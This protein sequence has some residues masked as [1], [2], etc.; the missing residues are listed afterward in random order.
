MEYYGPDETLR[1]YRPKQRRGR[2]EDRE[3]E[4]EP[5]EE[6]PENHQDIGDDG[7]DEEDE[8]WYIHFWN[9]VFNRDFLGGMLFILFLSALTWAIMAV[10]AID[11]E[12]LRHNWQKVFFV[13]LLGSALGYN[14]GGAIKAETDSKTSF[15]LGIFVTLTVLIP[16]VFGFDKI[17]SPYGD[18]FIITTAFFTWIILTEFIQDHIYV[19]E[20]VWF[21]GRA[22]NWALLVIPFLHSVVSI[23]GLAW[24]QI[25]VAGLTGFIIALA[26]IEFQ[27]FD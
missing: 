20:L 13:L 9:G 10:T 21:F 22:A 3:E 14:L 25:I 15:L 4:E 11:I 16:Y 19:E 27:D 8:E 1:E 2:P 24:S 12:L 26:L 5:P 7:E 18:M 17:F 23:S 6:P